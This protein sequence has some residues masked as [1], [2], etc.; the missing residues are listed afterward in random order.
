MSTAITLIVALVAA[1]GVYTYLPGTHVGSKA[2]ASS[3]FGDDYVSS[4]AATGQGPAMTRVAHPRRLLPAVPPP[5]G[6]GGFVLTNARSRDLVLFDP[7]RPVHYVVSGAEPWPGANAMLKAAIAD[8]SDA[9]GLRFVDDG[10]SSEPAFTHRA[11]YQPD[12]Y[13]KR[14]APVL[15]AWTDAHADRELAGNVLGIGGGIGM[16]V[17]NQ[18]RLV[19]GIV[20][21]DG[22]DL[23]RLMKRPTDRAEVH[24]VLL[25]E[26]G[27][28]VGLLH[29]P[30]TSSVMNPV[31]QHLRDFSAGDRRG[32]AA[33]G[34]GP[35]TTIG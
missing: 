13:G 27:H 32:L 34:N 5:T 16:T 28:L 35:C 9:T 10:T 21:Y 12:R 1:A 22:P 26:L 8:V 18:P 4:Q 19:S 30:D 15:I 20:Y 17:D 6:S 33:A 24:V 23:S 7:C 11:P 31:A 25:H 14:W 29:E 2:L 3:Q